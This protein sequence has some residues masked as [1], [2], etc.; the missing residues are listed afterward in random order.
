MHTNKPTRV[1]PVSSMPI[2]ILSEL[3]IKYPERY[4]MLSM[5]ICFP[6]NL[7]SSF[8]TYALQDLVE[9]FQGFKLAST[10]S[11]NPAKILHSRL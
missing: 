9:I 1:T 2:G 8:L 4:I 6:K 11:Y 5:H 3:R 7:K 10:L